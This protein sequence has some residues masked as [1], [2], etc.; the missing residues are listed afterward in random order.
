MK[1]TVS[2][3]LVAILCLGLFAGC[4]LPDA[5]TS[6]SEDVT[7]INPL[8]ETLDV[9]N[10]SDC[11][12]AVSL[13]QGDVFADD[14]GNTM[15]KAKVYNYECYD[16]ADIAALAEHDVIVRRGE[17]IEITK[18]ERLDSG[19]VRINGGE[20]AGGFDLAS[21][22]STVYFEVGMDDAKAYYELG[23]VTLPI[24]DAFVY[25]DENGTEYKA[26][27]FTS[28]A[29]IVYDFAPNTTTIVIEGGVVTQMSK[30]ILP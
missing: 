13:A 3:L 18:L 4:N 25:R 17:E 11:T 9:A 30:V 26:D 7:I 27:A 29:A 8:P 24:S 22:E 6:A 15:M 28:D 2:I 1:K 23:S 14:S 10:L 12:V 20:E 21:D 5:I 19:L 16:M